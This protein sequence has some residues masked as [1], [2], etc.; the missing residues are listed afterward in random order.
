MKKILSFFIATTLLIQSPAFAVAPIE[1][2]AK[3]AFMIDANTHAVLMNKE[4]DVVMHP[5]S[6]SKLMTLYILFSR[7]KEGR[8]KLDSKFAVSEKAWRTQGSKTFV[9]IGSEMTVEELIHG[10]II[11]SGNDACIVVAEGIAGSEDAFVKE[12]NDTAAKLGMGKSHFVNATGLPDDNHVMSARD[13][14]TLAEHIIKDFPDYYPYFALK[15]YT[16]NHITQHNRNRLLGTVG[17]DGLKTGHTDAG[18]YGIT[19]S[20][21][22]GDRR[23]ILVINGM[24]SD[25]ERMKQGDILLRWGFREFE[26]KTLVKQGQPVAEADVWMG[27]KDTVKLVPERDLVVTLPASNEAQKNTKFVLKYTGPLAT[28]IAKGAHVADLVV[29]MDNAEPVTIPL[30]ADEDVAPLSG[31]SRMMAALKYHLHGKPAV[32]TPA[33]APAK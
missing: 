14:A 30:L 16:Y 23:L 5:S 9:G 24:E 27:Q 6:M 4:G 10:I 1:T 8:L 17:V 21:L 33:A 15:E 26:N 29:T 2:T 18:G 12:M 19:L 32:Q 13:L 20:A 28:P 11:Q 7:L 3:Q 22:Q 25:D 31:F